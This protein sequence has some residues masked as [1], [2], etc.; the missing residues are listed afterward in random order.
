MDY[1]DQDI[2]AINQ[3]LIPEDPTELNQH[4]EATTPWIVPDIP[5]N[6]VRSGSFRDLNGKRFANTLHA[7]IY[8]FPWY[9]SF[10]YLYHGLRCWWKTH[11]WPLR[12]LYFPK[13]RKLDKQIF[14]EVIR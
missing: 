11:K 14:L 9:L 5:L 6:S 10:L 8:K 4:V 1:W 12:I 2:E 13:D 3:Q 7:I